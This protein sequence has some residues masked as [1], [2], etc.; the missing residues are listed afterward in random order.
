MNKF[1]PATLVGMI[2]LSPAGCGSPAPAPPGP[3]RF[4]QTAAPT[5]SA[6][7]PATAYPAPMAT[8]PPE[9]TQTTTPA[10]EL[11]PG[12]TQ[13]YQALEQL[14]PSG[15]IKDYLTQKVG[16]TAFGGKVFSAYQ[17]MGTEQSGQVTRLYLWALVQEYYLDGQTLKDGTGSSLPVV[18]FI[19]QQAG[20]YQIFD[21]K[22][23]GEGYGN[24]TVN[25]PAWILPMI[26]LPADQYNLRVSLLA[27]ENRLAAEA[28]YGIK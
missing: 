23:A 22:D 28:F 18:L 4:G 26:Q 13:T 15:T 12:S 17:V 14:I 9:P 6:G 5:A 20:V 2:M 8:M 11:I 1:L 19:R 25:F 27:D 16:A 24:L 3:A 10:P 7:F 21:Y